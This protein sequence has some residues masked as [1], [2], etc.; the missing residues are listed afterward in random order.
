MSS[1]SVR[2][3][4]ATHYVADVENVCSYQPPLHLTGTP[5]TMY[6]LD[7]WLEVSTHDAPKFDGIMELRHTQHIA[8]N[9]KADYCFI[10]CP[11]IDKSHKKVLVD[12][13]AIIVEALS[14][15][16]R[17]LCSASKLPGGPELAILCEDDK[18]IGLVVVVSI[19]F[20]FFHKPVPPSGDISLALEDTSRECLFRVNSAELHTTKVMAK[21][22]IRF[23]SSIVQMLCPEVPQLSRGLVQEITK[24][25]LSP[26][27]CDLKTRLACAANSGD[28]SAVKGT[29][30]SSWDK[31]SSSFRPGST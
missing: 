16:E 25:F 22:D 18:S 23:I 3:D 19:L 6:C 4:V 1:A 27:Q 10:P 2:G 24:F 9:G 13:E 8:S 29:V 31:L 26:N 15:Y 28:D 12:I 11:S 20:A 17:L 14:F 21:S 5:I 7:S 30:R